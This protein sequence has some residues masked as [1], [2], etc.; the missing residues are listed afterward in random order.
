MQVWAKHLHDG[1][2]GVVA[3]NRGGRAL[4]AGG[5]NITWTMIGLPQTT[6]AAVRDLWQH[7][8]MGKFAGVYPCPEIPSHDVLALRVTPTPTAR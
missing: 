6:V 3:L 4:P 2:V 8:D 1:S 7:K 5:L